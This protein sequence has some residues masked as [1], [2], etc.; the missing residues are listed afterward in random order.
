[1]ALDPAAA[2][3]DIQPRDPV[4]VAPPREVAVDA[5]WL[6]HGSILANRVCLDHWLGRDPA[7]IGPY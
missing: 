7:A 2:A 1:M 4:L 3:P 6:S 5:D